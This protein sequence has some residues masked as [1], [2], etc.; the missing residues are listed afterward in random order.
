MKRTVFMCFLLGSL[1]CS[2]LSGLVVHASDQTVHTQTQQMQELDGE[3][4]RARIFDFLVWEMDLNEA[5][6]AG[7]I[8][9]LFFESSFLPDRYG[10]SGT[11]YGICQ[12]HKVRFDHLRSWCQEHGYD[13]TTLEGQLHFMQYELTTSYPAVERGLRAVPNTAQGAYQAAYLWCKQYEIPADTENKAIQRGNYARQVYWPEYA[14]AARQVSVTAEEAFYLPGH[15]IALTLQATQGYRSLQLEITHTD[16]DTGAQTVLPV[17][18]GEVGDRTLQFQDSGIYTVTLAA[19]YPGQVLRSPAAKFVVD[20]HDWQATLLQPATSQ[21]DGTLALRC[22]VCGAEKT[23]QVQLPQS[24]HTTCRSRR[25]TDLA[26]DAWYHE[27]V[28]FAVTNQL[29][30]GTGLTTFS[31]DAPMTR[32]MLVTVLWRLEGKPQAQQQAGFTDVPAGAYYAA[33]VN[34][35]AQEGLV[36]GVTETAFAP[37]EPVSR[38]QMA[39]ILYRHAGAAAPDGTDLSGFADGGQVSAYA[40]DA[41]RWAVQTRLIQGMT[42]GRLAP[43]QAATRAQVAAILQRF[44]ELPG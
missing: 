11:S 17:Q 40:R 35:A 37:Q 16:P 26:V 13:Y 12:W 9:N 24:G 3:A 34:W 38:Q 8:S 19:S 10:D 41:M 42:D 32:G 31:P 7:V 2:S 28:D 30:A 14:P 36:Y 25:Y 44:A 20:E 6:A 1:L 23:E 21:Q 5:A 18:S 27:A 22:R 33:A 4:N 29:F 43:A 39:A 15:P